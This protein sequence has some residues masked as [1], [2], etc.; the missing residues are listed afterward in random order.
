M[1]DY[2]RRQQENCNAKSAVSRGGIMAVLDMESGIT[3]FR[4]AAYASR[5]VV[6]YESE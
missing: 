3:L 2:G 4:G 5:K 6:L 1:L